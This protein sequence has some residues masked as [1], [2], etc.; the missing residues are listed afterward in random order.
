MGTGGSV[1]KV[2]RMV[3]IQISADRDTVC[4][5]RPQCQ[6]GVVRWQAEGVCVLSK[7]VYISIGRKASFHA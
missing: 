2:N 1:F 6:S 3:S 5:S 7:T 4:V